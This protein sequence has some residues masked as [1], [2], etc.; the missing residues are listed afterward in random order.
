MQDR[1]ERGMELMRRLLPDMPE[2]LE[3]ALADIAPDMPGFIIDF[4]A[5][6]ILSRPGPDISDRQTATVAALMALGNAPAQLAVHIRGSLNA[7]LSPRQIIEIIYVTMIFSGFASALNAITVAREAFREAGVELPLP[8]EAVHAG[9]E[10]PT[11]ADRH[12]KGLAVMKA[13]SDRAG[14]AVIDALADIA[15]DMARFIVDFSYGEIFSRTTLS[16]RKKEIAM[17]AATAARG[18]MAPQLKVH[19]RAALVVGVSKE[20]IVE[21]LLQMAVYAGFPAALNALAA[22]REA[23]AEAEG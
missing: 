7:G 21:I 9:T 20:D 13:T 1:H 12:T 19:I 23:F 14:N 4:A 10:E 6:E 8:R 3:T 17:I 15:P 18:T 5:G 16:P 22:A 2:K 11:P